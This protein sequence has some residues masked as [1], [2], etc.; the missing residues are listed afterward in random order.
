MIKGLELKTLELKL[1]LDTGE[2][3][4]DKLLADGLVDLAVGE[5][6]LLELPSLQVSL[7]FVKCS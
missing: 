7:G 4:Q 6:K 3:L 2:V 1:G 5:L